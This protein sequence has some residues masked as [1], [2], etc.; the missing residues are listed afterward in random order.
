M[1]RLEKIKIIAIDL[2]QK[3]FSKINA[4]IIKRIVNPVIENIKPNVKFINLRLIV[5]WGIPISIVLKKRL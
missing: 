4:K 5:N 3:R 2:N 1:L